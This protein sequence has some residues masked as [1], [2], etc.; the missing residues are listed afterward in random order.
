LTDPRNGELPPLSTNAP[1][2]VAVWDE[3]LAAPPP[4]VG[5]WSAF[6][7]PGGRS[8]PNDD[9]PETGKK[10]QKAQDVRVDVVAD[11]GLSWI[12]VNTLVSIESSD[13][14]VANGKQD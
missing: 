13:H 14:S 7:D 2:L 10:K 4:I 8:I 3:V 1:Y 12:R 5:I 11:G 9:A 6:P